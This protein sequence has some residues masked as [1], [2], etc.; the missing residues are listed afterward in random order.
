MPQYGGG[1]G[2]IAAFDIDYN[3]PVC[4]IPYEY[5]INT[6]DNYKWSKYW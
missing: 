3:K 1:W 4:E 6:Y 2:L 5:V